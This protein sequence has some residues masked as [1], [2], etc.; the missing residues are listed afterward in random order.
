[1]RQGSAPRHRR[2]RRAATAG[3]AQH[4]VTRSS[5]LVALVLALLLAPMAA[6]AATPRAARESSVFV[7]DVF[8]GAPDCATVR[9]R[10]SALPLRSTVLLSV[11]QGPEFLPD[12]RAGS[13]RLRCALHALHAQH[14]RVKALLLQDAS[15]LDRPAEAVR[16]VRALARLQGDG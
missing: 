9:A 2:F 8:L 15:F 3:A 16:R 7:Y 6:V 13:R 1:M 4:A 14:R 5:H 10:L 11:E 12:S